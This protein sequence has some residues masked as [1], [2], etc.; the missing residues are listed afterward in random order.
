M[1]KRKHTGY[2]SQERA[3]GESL[4]GFKLCSVAAAVIGSAVVGGMMSDGP[5]APDMTAQ[6]TAAAAQAALS[7]EQ[8]DWSKQIYEESRPAREAAIR[9]AQET[10]QA[11]LDGMRSST[12][13][14]NEYAD[15]NRNTFRPLEQGIV[16]DAAGYDTPQRREA[17]AAKANADVEMSLAGQRG[18]SNRELEASG[19][20]PGS[21]KQ[22]A[23]QGFMD[24][25]AAKLKAGAANQARTQVETIGAARK[26]DAASLG[27]NLPSNQATSAGIAMQQ[28][29]SAVSAAQVPGS[30][31][32]GGAALMNSGFNGAQQGLAGAAGTYGNIANQ[33]IRMQGQNDNSA[34][35]GALGSVAGQY[36]GSAS[37]S[38]AISRGIAAF[39]DVN[40]KENIKPVN[41][42]EALQQVE[43]TP[44]STYNY[45]AGTPGAK[46]AGME[47]TAGPMAQVVAKTMGKKAAPGG[48]KIDLLAMNGIAMAAIQGL[49]KKV[50]GLMAAQ[51]I[52]A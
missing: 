32:A 29:N 2:L 7:R 34:M 49:S 50:D 48:K 31:T 42:D 51:G 37:G 12:A 5:Q 47:K 9:T 25:N 52:P 43:A 41:P 10:S 1:G 23:M 40:M 6:N 21:G 15:Y 26:M 16:S 35:F 27:R 17:Q 4:L 30:V 39:S 14:A 18:I 8:L 19:A 36:A 3:C 46:D 28:G 33:Q 24:I 38:A 45:K 20:M 11:Q 44:V 22:L 13:L